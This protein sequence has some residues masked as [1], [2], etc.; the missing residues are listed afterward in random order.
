MRVE[1]KRGY[2]VYKDSGRE[3]LIVAPHSGPALDIVTS[4]DD[5]SETVASLCWKRM[6]GTLIISSMP[7]ERL[8]GVDF[9]RDIPNLK[10]ALDNFESFLNRDNITKRY[11]YMKKYGWVAKDESDYETR[12]KIYQGF[13]EE[14][15][16]GENIII[17]H[18]AF[19]KLKF[20]PSI[21]DITTFSGEKIKN[22]LTDEIVEKINGKYSYFLEKIKEDYKEA[23][24][25]E[26]KR[27]VLNIL[28][29][30]KTLKSDKIG[31]IFKENIE[32]DLEKINM[33]ADKIAKRRV[34]YSLTP[35]NYLEAVKNS[36]ENMPNPKI[37]FEN[38]FSGELSFGPK[39]KLFP[40]KNK[41]IIQVEGSGFLNFWHPHIAAE[42][43]KDIYEMVNE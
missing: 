27:M 5:H 18:K 8:W 32:K 43:I 6:G 25:F 7:R 13:W 38:V 24:M 29:I 30:Y 15:S 17:V 37:T 12:L 14:V 26:S 21:L 11:D 36:L 40:L 9:N 35:T 22:K 33:Y 2:I 20:V 19:P 42:I 39:R 10:D 34:N 16:K 31:V 4:R 1:F 28:R 23:I 3:P 41:K